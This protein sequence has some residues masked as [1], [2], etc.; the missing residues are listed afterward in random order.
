MNE[1]IEHK[2]MMVLVTTALMT[3]VVL[4]TTMIT[5]IDMP[6]GYI[7][8]GDFTIMI[9]ASIAPLRVAMI[10]AGVGS[11]LA[12]L[13]SGYPLYIFFTFFIKMGEVVILHYM[14]KAITNKKLVF[15]PFFTAGLFM[16]LMYGVAA[17][18]I[19]GNIQYF[20]VAVLGDLPQGLISALLATLLYPQYIRM[21]K[22]LKGT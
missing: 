16:V 1:K 21:S 6:I 10:A 18:I 13:L 11:A 3:A 22:Y 12:D 14:L 7:N 8:L 15:V 19:S 17:V 9:I 20:T 5:K 4:A 2:Q